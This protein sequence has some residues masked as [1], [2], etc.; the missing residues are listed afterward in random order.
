MGISPD[1]CEQSYHI[2]WSYGYGALPSIYTF[3]SPIVNVYTIDP[4]YVGE[5]KVV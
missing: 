1:C 2:P 4:A 5:H 3:S